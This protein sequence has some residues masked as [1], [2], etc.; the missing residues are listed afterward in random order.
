MAIRKIP[1]WRENLDMFFVEK[2]YLPLPAGWPPENGARRWEVLLLN[3]KTKAQETFGYFA[4]KEQSEPSLEKLLGYLFFESIYEGS[5]TK[6][7]TGRFNCCCEFK[8]KKII[9]RFN[10]N[11]IKLK[12][13]FGIDFENIREFMLNSVSLELSL[14]P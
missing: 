2:S 8:A 10:R 13:L 11:S 5:T 1:P 4:P 6:E 14:F 7:I 9:D 3:R 12:R